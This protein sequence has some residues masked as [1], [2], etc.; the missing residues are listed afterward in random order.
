MNAIQL[1]LDEGAAQSGTDSRPIFTQCDTTR[2]PP[3]YHITDKYTGAFQAI[4]DAYGV[5]TYQEVNPAP[6]TIITFPFL[7]AVMFGDFGHGIIMALFALY[8]VKNETV[9]EKWKAGGEIWDTMFSGRYIILLMGLFSI[10][11]GLIYNDCFSKSMSLF[12]ESRWIMPAQHTI[13]GDGR[14]VVSHTIT[15]CTSEEAQKAGCFT[16]KL[17]QKRAAFPAGSS[18]FFF[19]SFPNASAPRVYPSHARTQYYI[20]A[21]SNSG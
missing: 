19:F 20:F 14:F 15:D 17:L 16:G 3:T 13:V 1:V 11:T 6:F 18:S 9:L 5:A 8:L 4:V 12:G 10:Y 21:V 7:F 2:R